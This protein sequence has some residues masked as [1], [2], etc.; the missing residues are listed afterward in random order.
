MSVSETRA[1][2]ATTIEASQCD[3]CRRS[4]FPPLRVCPDCNSEEISPVQLTGRGSLYSYTIVHVGRGDLPTP[5]ALG[6][7][8]LD[9]GV[10]VFAQVDLTSDGL[11]VG[12]LME[13]SRGAIRTLPDGSV[14]EG[15]RFKRL[16][17]SNGE[18][19]KPDA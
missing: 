10:R 18:R 12:D 7:I 16:R 3:S 15:Y 5:Y 17:S 1:R 13:A 9:A 11:H 19:S 4:W 14:L 6:M 2:A 8:D